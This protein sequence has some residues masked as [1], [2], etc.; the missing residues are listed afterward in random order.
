MNEI[1]LQAVD[2]LSKVI[3]SKVPNIQRDCIRFYFSVYGAKGS[4][5]SIRVIN[6]MVL[7]CITYTPFL[8]EPDNFSR[9]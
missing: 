2:S 7:P 8:N 5:K 9:G 4:I 3:A 6:G 1:G